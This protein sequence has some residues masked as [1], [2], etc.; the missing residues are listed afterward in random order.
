VT[1][2]CGYGNEHSGSVK[3]DE[4]IA[5]SAATS[6]LRTL[7]LEQSPLMYDIKFFPKNQCGVYNVTK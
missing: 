3:G 1:G 6:F 4:F 5:S 2:S 7:S